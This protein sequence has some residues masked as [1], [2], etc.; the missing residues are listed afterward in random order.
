VDVKRVLHIVRSPAAATGAAAVAAPGAT[1]GAMGVP[2]A[3]VA[4][5]DVLVYTY[6]PALQ[7]ERAWRLWREP[8]DAPCP[9]PAHVQTIDT[10]TVCRLAFELDAVVVW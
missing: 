8:A 5:H 9:A 7:P 6:V 10:D 4:E 1:S 3:A 2:G